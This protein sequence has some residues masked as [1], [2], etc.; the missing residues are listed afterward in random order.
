MIKNF[1]NRIK[2]YQKVTEIAAEKSVVKRKDVKGWE[3]ADKSNKTVAKSFRGVTT[4]QRKSNQIQKILFYI[5]VL[6]I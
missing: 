5:V 2:I 3:L 4:N 6:M 1:I